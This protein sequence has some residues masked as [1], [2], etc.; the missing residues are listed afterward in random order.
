MSIPQMS[1]EEMNQWR[2]NHMKEVY[3]TF[4]ISKICLDFDSENKSDA[5]KLSLITK[6]LSNK[7]SRN[8]LGDTSQYRYSNHANIGYPIMIDL[9]DDDDE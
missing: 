6:D 5:L 1:K 9:S 7:Y 2:L 8:Y 3:Q 4:Q